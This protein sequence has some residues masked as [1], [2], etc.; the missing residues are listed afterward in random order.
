MSEPTE[1]VEMAAATSEVKP[2]VESVSSPTPV[3]AS[4]AAAKEEDKASPSKSD[5]QKTPVDQKPKETAGPAAVEAAQPPLPED[6]KMDTEVC[7]VIAIYFAISK[8]HP[9][10]LSFLGI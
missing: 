10:D 6:E 1:T 5:S 8:C 7:S 9:Y 3:P 2:E 4:P